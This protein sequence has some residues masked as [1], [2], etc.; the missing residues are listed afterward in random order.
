MGSD[1][2]DIRKAAIAK[3]HITVAAHLLLRVKMLKPRR[4]L[5]DDI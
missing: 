4:K 2:C 3:F 1:L 5:F